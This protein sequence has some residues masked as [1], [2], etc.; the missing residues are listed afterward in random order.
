MKYFI[1]DLHF[2]HNKMVTFPGR[3]SF[4]LEQ[5]EKMYLDIINTKL[6]KD[7]FLY[8]LGDFAFKPE[9]VKHKIKNKNVVLIH[10]NHDPSY[11]KCVRVFGKS[12]F[13]VTK[14]IKIKD[15][16]VFLSHY[17]HLAWPA[18]HYGTFHLYG[19]VHDQRSEYWQQIPELSEMRSMDVSPESYFRQYGEF[20][21]FSEEQVYETLSKLKGHDNVEWYNKR[22]G[23]YEKKGA[24]SM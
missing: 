12:N 11:E 14:D 17:P 4:T 9:K 18:S 10:G 20:G 21:I 7:D 16:N 13:F 8:L 5:W 15:K 19:H 3:T 1:S 22:N 6:T 23:K 24:N 2:G